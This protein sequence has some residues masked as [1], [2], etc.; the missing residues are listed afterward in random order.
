M[1]QLHLRQ[2]DWVMIA[3]GL[4]GERPAKNKGDCGTESWLNQLFGGV[5]IWCCFFSN[6]HSEWSLEILECCTCYLFRYAN[7]K[8]I[9]WEKQNKGAPRSFQF[10]RFFVGAWRHAVS[11]SRRLLKAPEEV[12]QMRCK[13]WVEDEVNPK[14]IRREVLSTSIYIWD[15]EFLCATFVCVVKIDGVKAF[16]YMY[17]YVYSSHFRSCY[18]SSWNRLI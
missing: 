1:W 17:V 14:G 18:Y 3:T 2:D 7:W 12:I 16:K 5:I 4:H 13:K 6:Q 8:G 15:I 11:V 9:F 10:S